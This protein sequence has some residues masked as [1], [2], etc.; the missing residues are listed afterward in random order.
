MAL[1]EFSYKGSKVPL[2]KGSGTPRRSFALPFQQGGG[3]P[4]ISLY[5]RLLCELSLG[6]SEDS[7]KG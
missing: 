7:Y 6:L 3:T 5:T 1:K 2:E 4:F